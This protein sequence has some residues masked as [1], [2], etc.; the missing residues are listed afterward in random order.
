MLSATSVYLLPHLWLL[1]EPIVNAKKESQFKYSTDQIIF[2]IG[3]MVSFIWF[4][5][6]IPGTIL[7]S[8]SLST[9]LTTITPRTLQ[10]KGEWRIDKEIFLCI[11]KVIQDDHHYTTAWYYQKPLKYIQQRDYIL[12]FILKQEKMRRIHVWHRVHLKKDIV[13]QNNISLVTIHCWWDGSCRRY[14]I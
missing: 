5:L 8:P 4:V 6:W 10:R 1:V 12:I 7:C 3:Y 11:N 2:R 14:F 9:P 13:Q